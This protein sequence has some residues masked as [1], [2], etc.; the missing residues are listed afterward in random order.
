M[1]KS[2]PK[3]PEPKKAGVKK[4]AAA[5]KTAAG[6]QKTAA[7]SA[8]KKTSAAAKKTAVKKAAPKA[9]AAP[10]ELRYSDG[11]LAMIREK[12]LELAFGGDRQMLIWLGKAVLG[13]TPPAARPGAG[14]GEDEC[15]LVLTPEEAEALYGPGPD[16]AR[17]PGRR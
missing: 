11:E 10:N 8:A 14:D 2:E 15:V 17:S 7:K 1:K 6:K 5:K 9:P 4:N 16:P 3:K 12:Q 13:Q